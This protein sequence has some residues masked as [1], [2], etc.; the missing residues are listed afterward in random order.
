[1]KSRSRLCW[2]VLPVLVLALAPVRSP[3]Q[4]TNNVGM[5]VA[6]LRED[7]RILDER[8]RQMAVEMEELK[9]ENRN[10]RDQAANKSDFVTIQQFN[11]SLSEL[12]KALRAGDKEVALQMTSQL[13]KLA[14]QT[15]SAINALSKA[16]ATSAPKPT[17]QF[18]EIPPDVP[19][20]MYEVEPGDNI[21]SIARKL[22]STIPDIQN[23]NKIADPKTLQ[24]GQVIFVP[25]RKP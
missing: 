8:V 19:G 21:S 4:P 16:S 2:T 1:M 13:E 6:S 25:Q 18:T 9:R 23:A 14:R 7:M 3:A 22:G 15:Q 17:F 12:E 24:A 10:L 5:I 20:T 11:A